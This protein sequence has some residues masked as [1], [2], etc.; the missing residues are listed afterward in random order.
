MN[1]NM[2]K[3]H[4]YVAECWKRE[5]AYAHTAETLMEE[6]VKDCNEHKDEHEI[7]IKCIRCIGA[8][9]GN[10]VFAVQCLRNLK[11]DD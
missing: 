1:N 5:Q 7:L 3:A 9:S 11:H 10:S 6:I 8:G 4:A 2:E